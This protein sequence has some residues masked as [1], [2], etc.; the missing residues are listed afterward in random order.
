MPEWCFITCCLLVVSQE[1]FPHF[2]GVKL[3]NITDSLLS[4][5][6]LCLGPHC[7]CARNKQMSPSSPP[8][9]ADSSW[10]AWWKPRFQVFGIAFVGNLFISLATEASVTGILQNMS[11]L[12]SVS[13]VLVQRAAPAAYIL[14]QQWAEV[15]PKPRAVGVGKFRD[16]FRPDDYCSRCQVPL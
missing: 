12:V 8:V 7:Q 14:L 16:H 13:Y 15:I 6:E 9:T 11:S 2:A 10:D 4:S 1:P 3:L 5:R